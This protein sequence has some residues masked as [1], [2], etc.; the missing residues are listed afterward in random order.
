[1]IFNPRYS[2]FDC[3]MYNLHQR[4]TSVCGCVWGVTPLLQLLEGES[5]NND[6]LVMCAEK[7]QEECARNLTSAFYEVGKYLTFLSY[8]GGEKNIQSSYDAKI[9]NR[10]FVTPNVDENS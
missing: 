6:T 2:Q 1:M 10:A 7:L 8:T 5:D 4:I 9:L 3:E